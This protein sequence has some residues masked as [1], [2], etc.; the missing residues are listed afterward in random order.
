MPFAAYDGEARD[1]AT[2]PPET[3]S[4]GTLDAL[5]VSSQTFADL[6]H[7]KGEDYFLDRFFDY[8]YVEDVLRGN[9]IEKF[10][11]AYVDFSRA[12]D[13]STCADTCKIAQF[14]T[15]AQGKTRSIAYCDVTAVSRILGAPEGCVDVVVYALGHTFLVSTLMLD[16]PSSGRDGEGND[17]I[18]CNSSG[19]EQLTVD[20]AAEQIADSPP[21]IE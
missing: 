16:N 18:S 15:D 5:N 2:G 4:P 21:K 7:R 6:I 17:E 1:F 12:V 11:K 13:P 20:A 8:A 9:D 10:W 19:S 3:K 14:V